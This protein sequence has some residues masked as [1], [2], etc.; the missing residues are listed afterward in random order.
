MKMIEL[1]EPETS[2]YEGPN[3]PHTFKAVFMAGA[4]GAGKTTI[5]NL[6]FGGTGLKMLNVDHFWQ[7]YNMTNRDQDE[8]EH[9]EKV[10]KQGGLY[11]MGR[12]GLVIDGT[13]RNPER[14]L[15]AKSTLEDMGYDTAMVFVN[16]DLETAKRRAKKRAQAAGK[17]HGRKVDPLYQNAASDGVQAAQDTYQSLFSPLFWIVDNIRDSSP[18]VRPIGLQRAQKETRAWL[19]SPPQDPRAQEWLRQAREQ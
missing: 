17:D 6:L 11:K 19:N 9:W 18:G 7:L 5:A 2:L 3:D 14:M 16:A 1:I 15:D 12:L 8:K 13:A 10:T 4:P